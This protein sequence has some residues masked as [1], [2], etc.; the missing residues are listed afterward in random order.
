MLL[1]NYTTSNNRAAGNAWSI[2]TWCVHH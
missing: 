1:L 2:N